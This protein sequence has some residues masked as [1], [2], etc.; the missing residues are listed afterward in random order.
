MSEAPLSATAP[1][2]YRHP[3]RETYVRCARCDR[4]ICPSCM[5]V[6]S[7]GH[8]CPDCVAIGRKTQ[9]QVRTAFGGTH[10][11]A[12][13]YVTIGL[14]VIN[15][16]MLII[17]TLSA[18]SPGSTLF[19][20]GLGGLLGGSTPLDTHL[21]VIGQGYIGSN[22]VPY[23]VSQ[24]EYYRLFTAMFM[25]FGLIHLGFNMLTLW[26]IGRPL[27]TLL[28]PIR[29]LALYLICGIG[30]NVACYLFSPGSLSAGASTALFGLFG[31]LF[32]LLRK[33]NLNANA[34]M[35]I[36]IIN[37]VLTFTASDISIPGHI[38]GLLT[39]VVVGYAFAHAP[40]A[41]RTLIQAASVVVALVIFG[42]AS[43]YQTHHIKQEAITA[44]TPISR[45]FR[46][47]A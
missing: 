21:A 12:Q 3:S 24:G 8:Q 31:A 46:P 6:A 11:G 4:P 30:G 20:G 37:L 13:G 22:V 40:Q 32:I 7:V 38:G 28:G 39:G 44:A 14:I 5:N 34:L 45:E 42:A 33:L 23:G 18:K 16:I 1:V 26:Y 43:L 35:P 9:R 15:C 47:P 36:I 29:F 25:H 2:C 17:S 27:E 10:A 19:G 41:N